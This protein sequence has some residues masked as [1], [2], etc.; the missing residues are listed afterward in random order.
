MA[1]RPD[2]TPA[3]PTVFRSTPFF[4]RVPA[5]LAKAGRKGF[6]PLA[7]QG[8]VSL[9]NFLTIIL[10][11][12]AVSHGTLLKPDYGLFSVILEFMNFLITL[13]AGLITY[14]L[15]IRGAQT[16]NRGLKRFASASLLFTVAF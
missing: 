11:G 10:V 15:T 7:D 12:R 16:D 1:D 3:S 8:V 6:W 14:P 9:G 2:M 4:A 5:L 13:H